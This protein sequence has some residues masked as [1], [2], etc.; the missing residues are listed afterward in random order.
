MTG[1]ISSRALQPLFRYLNERGIPLAELLVD[2]APSPSFFCLESWVSEAVFA[3]LLD[4]AS[5]LS[6]DGE[7]VSHVGELAADPCYNSLLKP[8]WSLFEHPEDLLREAGSILNL[9]Q[10][11]GQVSILACRPGRVVIE[12]SPRP[13]GRR[14]YH[15]CTYTRHL[16][17]AI[18][19]LWHVSDIEVRERRCAVPLVELRPPSGERYSVSPEGQVWVVSGQGEGDAAARR[20]LG[21]VHEDGTFRIDDTLYAAGACQ[22]EIIW[23][24]PRRSRCRSVPFSSK[25]R[26]Y[27]R[28]L[29]ELQQQQRTVVALREQIQ[30]VQRTA[31][32]HTL[33]RTEDLRAKARQMALVEQSGRRFAS[34]LDP[35][36][37]LQEAGRTLREEMGYFTVAVYLLENDAW[38]LRALSSGDETVEQQPGRVVYD[39]PEGRT[40]LQSSGRPLIQGNILEHGHPLGL[41]P[42]GRGC[43]ALTVPLIASNRLLG[44]LDIQSPLS[45]HLDESDALLLHTLAPQVAIA[46][47]RSLLYRE[48]QRA[49]QRADAMAVLARVVTTTLELDRLLPR[50]LDHIRRVLPYDCAAVLLIENDLP[51]LATCHGLSS[52]GQ[53]DVTRLFERGVEGILTRLLERG[54]SV[55]VVGPLGSGE[56]TPVTLQPFEAWLAVPLTSRGS[57]IGAVLLASKQ[58]GTYGPKDLHLAEDL[59]GQISTAIE[60]ACLYSRI[61][62][63]KD[64][65]QT[66]YEIAREL[67]TDMSIDDLLRRI[68][69]MAQ[70]S[71]RAVAGSIILLGPEGSPS[72][73][74]LSRPADNFFS[75]LHAI[76]TRG[77]AGWV[78]REK[79]PLLIQD[80]Y[81]DPHWVQLPGD[82]WSTRSAIL[83]PLIGR[84]RMLG[85]L[86]VVH[87]QVARFDDDDLALL[88]S[89]AGQASIVVQRAHL[90]AAIQEE[91]VRLEAVIEGTA[92]AVI[93]LDEAN[94]ILHMNRPASE[95]FVTG[96]PASVGLP[97]RQVAIS[98]ALRS[99][100]PE[101]VGATEQRRVEVPLPDGRTFYAALNPIP[102][103]G[104][105][106]TM[107]DITRLKQ[108]DQMK[109]DFVATVSHDLRTPLGAV[110]GFAEMLELAG[111]LNEDQIHFANRIM[112]SVE[113]MVVLVEDLL[114]LAKIEAGVEMAMAP[115][116]IAAV[117]AEVVDQMAGQASLKPVSLHVDVPDDLPFVWGNGR[118]LEQVVRNLLD[119]AIKYAP[120]GGNVVL[121]AYSQKDA[122][123]VDVVDD[124]PG[125]PAADQLHVFEKFYRARKDAQGISG[126]GL[127]L[128]IARS[129]VLAHHGNIWVEGREGE[130][131]T[132]SFCIP[133]W[134]GQ[135]TPFG[136]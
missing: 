110:Q 84:D 5:A 28:A 86:T 103:V 24:A 131:A 20:Q 39:Q 115:C 37:L 116:Q 67:N 30:H 9:L 76:I 133:V 83:V 129:I 71:V 104:S 32:A 12:C 59:A 52:Q 91:R 106:I 134:G 98:P 111:S 87:P 77:A 113:G 130:G 128:S 45:E 79:R 1:Q 47:E 15:L 53:Q 105:V 40:I 96:G 55:L 135:Q 50:A 127:G 95:L 57:T 108:L 101:V 125:I 22:Y 124:G 123:Q 25:E 43:S 6:G 34:I 93:V 56:A 64:R 38:V 49:R 16:L 31:E 74:I 4:R 63:E 92:D 7:L 29:R 66:L 90:F 73:S 61:R 19:R 48:E 3:E 13:G 109:S 42:L 72:H 70:S 35:E 78:I 107:Q 54:D 11:D 51:N 60:N 23:A 18:P 89:I 136:V 118:R 65:L 68:L 14:G 117:I 112:S 99:L 126:T 33:E 100:L 88:S 62:H 41:P 8:E 36:A 58:H 69:E 46:L 120:P 81:Q 97:L 75:L 102:G 2:L 21:D 26:L 119:N 82:P 94:R 114:D 122:L 132:F 85:V 10:R 44:V 80:T 27:R 121:R 17:A